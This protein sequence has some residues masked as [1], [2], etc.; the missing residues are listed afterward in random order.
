VSAEGHLARRVDSRGHE[1]ST[2]ELAVPQGLAEAPSVPVRLRHARV[3]HLPRLLAEALGVQPGSALRGGPRHDGLVHREVG[4]LF[5]RL[6]GSQV[7]H[8]AAPAAV[9]A[10]HERAGALLDHVAVILP[11]VGRQRVQLVEFEGHHVDVPR[12]VRWEADIG[13]VRE[14]DFDRFTPIP[15][16]ELC[17][18]QFE[19]PRLLHVLPD[20][21]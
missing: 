2:R 10:A 6:W 17:F 12:S 3:A 9:A 1:N 8:P 14:G 11:E 16:D 7:G 13:D 5:G 21:G 18:E 15:L 19:S 4:D 20:C